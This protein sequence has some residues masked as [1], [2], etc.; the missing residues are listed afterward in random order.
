MRRVDQHGR[1]ARAIGA[2]NVVYNVVADHGDV[3]R[4]GT[5]GSDDFLKETAQRFKR[6]PVGLYDG[7]A[8]QALDNTDIPPSIGADQYRKALSL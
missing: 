3:F 1:Q 7:Y 2:D 4:H 6:E 5:G 8:E